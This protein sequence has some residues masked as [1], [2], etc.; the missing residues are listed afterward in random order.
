VEAKLT[1]DAVKTLEQK[2]HIP[3]LGVQVIDTFRPEGAISDQGN[4]LRFIDATFGRGGYT[5]LIRKA[6]PK[7]EIL[8]IDRDPDAIQ[9]ALKLRDET[10][11]QRLKICKGG[12]S[13]IEAIVRGEGWKSVD[14]ICFDLG[15]S[16]PQLDE[17]ERGFSFR[18][19]G[20]LDMRMSQEGVSASELIN[21]AD[22]KNIADIIFNYGEEKA[23]RKIARAIVNARA[24]KPIET[25]FELKEVIYQ[26]LPQRPHIRLDPATKTFQAIRIAVND[27][28]GQIE[29]ALFGAG[30]LLGD[31]G[32]L[33]VV[34][35]HSLEDRLAKNY[36][37]QRDMRLRKNVGRL[38]P[39][40]KPSEVMSVSGDDVFYN[41]LSKKPLLPDEEECK[42]NPRA[43]SAKLRAGR[44]VIEEA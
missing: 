30:K 43:R 4:G 1:D 17:A 41:M 9:Y 25:T 34:S 24:Q 27:E 44:R 20:P 32:V 15:V 12:F 39:Y 31:K 35:F 33:A 21:S 6:F 2:A 5:Q 29:E 37:K 36:F 42:H 18:H 13:N 23:A 11:D 38:L 3:V 22:E 8:V 40:E 26:V 28:L 19:N 14:G 7:A 10:K 16:S